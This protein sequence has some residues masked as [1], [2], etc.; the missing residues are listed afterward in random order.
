MEVPFD[1]FKKMD[2]R[3]GKVVNVEVPEGS[4]SVI[5][6]TVDFG[7]EK[8]IAMSGIK[9]HYK[10][11]ELIGKKFVFITNLE[12]KKILG[13]ESECMIMAADDEKGNIALLQPVKD[14]EAG[15]KIR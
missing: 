12:R 8:R 9:N 13:V 4:K 7:S 1:D 11:E 2:I 3:V 5:K 6:L 14:V 10:P 15:A